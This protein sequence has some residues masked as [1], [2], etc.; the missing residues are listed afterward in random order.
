MNDQVTHDLER[1]EAELS[2]RVCDGLQFASIRHALIFLFERGPAMQAALGAHPRG[3]LGPDGERHYIQ[4]DGGR[5]R[6]VHEVHATLITLRRALDNCRHELPVEAHCLRLRY[7]DPELVPPQREL[8]GG[9]AALCGDLLP[10]VEV[11]KRANVAPS[12][13]SSACGRAESFVLALLRVGG[14]VQPRPVRDEELPR[15]A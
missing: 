14:V 13:A 15:A 1:A 7:R 5:Q 4:V 10:F 8:K 12:T 11:G 2:R 3:Q 9:G 6:D